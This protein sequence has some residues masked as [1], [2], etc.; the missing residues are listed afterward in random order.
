MPPNLTAPRHLAG[1]ATH[2]HPIISITPWPADGK[3]ARSERKSQGVVNARAAEF[4]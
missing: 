3:G 4:G 1:D 2:F